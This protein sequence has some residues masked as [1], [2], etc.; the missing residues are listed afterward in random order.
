M[1]RALTAAVL[2]ALPAGAV[3]V[4]P[5]GFSDAIYAPGLNGPT[6]MAFAP[7]GRLFVCEK[8]GALRVVSA[9]GALLAAPFLS[10][11]VETGGERGLLGVTF[12]PQF[13]VNGFVYVYYTASTTTVHNR[14]SRF[15]ASGDVA[16]PGSETALLDL[17]AAPSMFH[18]GGALHFGLDG[19]L[20]IAVGDGGPS[21]NGQNIGTRFGKILR[22]EPDGSLPS[23]NPALIAGAGMTS[24]VNR[25][26]WCSGLRN[27]FTF[28]VQPGS[29]R[30]FVNDVGQATWEEVNEA[31]AGANYGW[32]ATEGDFVQ[33]SFPNFTRPRTSYTHDGATQ[34]TGA[35]E[36]ITG[37]VFYP[38]GG[39]FPAAYHGL[40]FFADHTNRWIRTLD[41]ASGA[42][43][44]FATD[45][46][47]PI[48]LDVGPD[49]ALYYLEFAAGAA[50]QG[51]VRRIASTSGTA[52]AVTLHPAPA[53][54]GAGQDATFTVSASGSAPLA[55]Q[56]QRDG[57]DLSGAITT[58]YTL[59]SA[60]VSDDGALFRCR[61]SNGF[62][63]ALSE[64]AA[65]SVLAD[66][67]PSA[68]IAAPAG[69]RAGDV[70]AYSGTA[71]DPE[72][73]ALG[74]AS[75]TWRVDFHHGTHLH[76]FVA[77]TSGS[78]LGS[79]TVPT[80][81]EPATDVWYRITLRVVDSA[82][83]TTT[84]TRDVPPV[85]SSFRLETDP[86]GLSVTLD[87]APAPHG[88]DVPGVVG[89][90]RTLGVPSTSGYAFAG[91]SDGGAET[92]DVATPGT[93]TTFVASF[94][95][96]SPAGDGRSSGGA[97]GALGLELL[98]AGLLRR[99]VR[100]AGAAARRGF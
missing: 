64:A 44:V 3:V 83:L 88:T 17:D 6:A 35:G 11:A 73:G 54:V 41:P 96:V 37:G 97:C 32:P 51:R 81:G 63:T 58:S 31:V 7:D 1:K 9:A 10:L 92:H 70:V 36:A 50:G 95:A 47:G 4:V 19:R 20:Y 76:P 38:M 48:D 27:P 18:N 2:L 94:T 68:S 29:G 91:W 26:I 86:P 90:L 5:S 52:P 40:Y 59:S 45:A 66:Q 77:D 82:G 67:P 43:T 39:S 75:F 49:G 69:Y 98:L 8:G 72:D 14:V 65:L 80:S 42:T 78:T 61:V 85:L 30:I 57:V 34:G 79:F 46:N 100:R 28:A 99:V 89:L 25:A 74:G 93:S 13:A 23:D 71:S 87:G 15:T 33:A 21:S 84:A 60:Q 53:T 22:I 55:Y 24:G 56:W 12:D 62:G 16:V